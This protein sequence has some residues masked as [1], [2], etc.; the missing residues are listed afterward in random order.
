[1]AKRQQRARPVMRAAARFQRHLDRRQPFEEAQQLTPPQIAPQYRSVGNID[2]V[3][4]EHRLGRVDGKALN[5]GHG[6]SPVRVFDGRTLAPDAAGPSTPTEKAQRIPP[7]S[8]HGRPSFGKI[9]DNG[10][11]A[12]AVMTMG[13]RNAV[14]GGMRS[15]SPPYTQIMK[16]ISGSGHRGPGPRN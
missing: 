16:R 3:Q 7:I 4:R 10:C 8:G 14:R 2:P 1:M 15:A 6:R 12:S 13:R 5:L 9:T 11:L